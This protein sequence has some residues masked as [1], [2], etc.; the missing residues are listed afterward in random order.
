VWRVLEEGRLGL[1]DD[2]AETDDCDGFNSSK[3][4]VL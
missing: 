4:E 1:H 3:T 2:F